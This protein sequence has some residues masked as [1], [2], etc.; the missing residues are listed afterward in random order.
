MKNCIITQAKDQSNR[1][2]DWIL[3]HKDQGFDTIIYFDDYSEDDSIENIKGISEQFNIEVIVNY[4]DNIGNKKSKRE[5]SD[6]NSYGG[7]ISIH[8]R[9][10]RSYNTGLRIAR[11]SNPSSICAII[12]V[13]EFLVTNSDRKVVDVIE[14]LMASEDTKHLY[15]NSFD[16]S[17]NFSVDEDWYT[18]NDNTK[19]R[20]DYEYRKNTIYATRGKSI[21]VASEILE[22]PQGPNYIH[23][24]RDFDTQYFNKMN[25]DD[26]DLLRMHHYRKP[27][28]D[29]NFKFVEDRTVL[30]KMINIKDVYERL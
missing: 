6:S 14:D 9:L 11:D 20:W 16:V 12:D 2:K 22:I 27:C 13:D 7:D 8:N 28:M 10:I 21:C 5:M 18:T 23:V 24:L 30:D 3:Y 1:L 4:S 15:V 25:V 26:Y 19:F 17:D 29:I